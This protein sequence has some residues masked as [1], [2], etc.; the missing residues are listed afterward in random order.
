MPY[1]L[2]YAGAMAVTTSGGVYPAKWCGEDS[3]A[4][5]LLRKSNVYFAPRFT[6]QAL[7]EGSISVNTRRF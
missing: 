1:G 6:E 4:H 2:D 7:D 5:L 3:L